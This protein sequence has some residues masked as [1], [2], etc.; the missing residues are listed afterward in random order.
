M[1]NRIARSFQ[2]MSR[3]NVFR[4]SVK[5]AGAGN[6]RWYIF[7]PWRYTGYLTPPLLKEMPCPPIG[8][9]PA[10]PPSTPL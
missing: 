4:I 10:Q 8:V 7:T 3:T 9:T 2:T 6:S 1:K 5:R